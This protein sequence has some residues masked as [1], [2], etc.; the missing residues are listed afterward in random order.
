[1][2]FQATLTASML[3]AG[4]LTGC[5]SSSTN[6][7]ATSD[8]DGTSEMTPAADV[9]LENLQGEWK[10]TTVTSGEGVSDPTAPS[11]MEVRPDGTY[12]FS[13]G[14][15]TMNGTFSVED[16]G[17][18]TSSPLAS[19]RMACP[20][21]QAAMETLADSTFSDITAATLTESG[22]LTIVGGDQTLVFQKS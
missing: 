14:C 5:A 1:M 9:T 21:D 11:E 13:A 18:L 7:E 4:I 19:T 3:V 2:R 12:T 10:V 16:G 17:I 22:E 8:P 20:E 15:N 6:D